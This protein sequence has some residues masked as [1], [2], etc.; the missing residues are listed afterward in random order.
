MLLLVSGSFAQRKIFLC[1]TD[2]TEAKL[3]FSS[4]LTNF[5]FL[6]PEFLNMTNFDKQIFFFKR[7]SPK[8]FSFHAAF[9]CFRS[10]TT[11][12]ISSTD[13]NMVSSSTEPAMYGGSFD[14]CSSTYPISLN[15]S[16]GYYLFCALFCA[17]SNQGRL[18]FIFLKSLPCICQNWYAAVSI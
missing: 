10:E 12:C 5:N 6:T 3:Y 9:Q 4:E 2:Y 17:A 14:D 16:R 18:L 7:Q 8:G 1:M 11:F 15:R 13:L